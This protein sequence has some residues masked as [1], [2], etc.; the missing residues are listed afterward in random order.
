M[1]TITFTITDEEELIL[2]TD[3]KDVTGWTEAMLDGHI[4]R[5]WKKFANKWSLVLLNDPNYTDPIPSNKTEFINL[6]KS[7]DDYVHPSDLLEQYNTPNK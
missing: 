3:L 1:K 7:R 5:S 6:V 2:L 4:N